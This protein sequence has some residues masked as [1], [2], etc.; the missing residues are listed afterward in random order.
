[1][2]KVREE[3][4]SDFVEKEPEN[5]EIQLPIAHYTLVNHNYEDPNVRPKIS[6]YG[7]GSC[8][9]LILYDKKNDVYAMSH[10]L[11]PES[12]REEKKGPLKFPHKFADSSI[13]DLLEELLKHGAEKKN[14]RAIVIGGAQI[15][16]NHYNNISELNIK[17]VKQKLRSL[18]IKILKEDT[19]GTK[20]RVLIYDTKYNK[21][22]VK[23]TGDT[24][25]KVVA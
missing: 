18:N 12:R 14:I 23:Y 1:M 8:I 2:F 9:G 22:L 19:G 15:F 25:F 16:Q 24:K 7:L 3:R 17:N 13:E 5:D 21:V 6:I 11:L 20:G 4:R 10:I